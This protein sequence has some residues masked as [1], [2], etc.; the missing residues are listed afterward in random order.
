VSEA[1]PGPDIDRLIFEVAE[2]KREADLEALL[3]L[4]EGRTFYCPVD[5]ASAAAL[6]KG[7]PYVVKAQDALR[8]PLARIGKLALVP[9]FTAATH[10]RLAGGHF[11]IEGREALAMALRAKGA[12]GVLLQNKADSWVGLDRKTIGRALER[13]R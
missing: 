9:L 3:G 12:D 2:H 7:A 10:A 8:V 1:A 6:P 11:A 5:P 13:G 4:I